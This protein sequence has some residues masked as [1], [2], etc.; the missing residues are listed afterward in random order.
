MELELTARQAPG[1][2][3]AQT[4]RAWLEIWGVFAG[5]RELSAKQQRDAAHNWVLPGIL[6]GWDPPN[7]VNLY[8]AKLTVG[9]AGPPPPVSKAA[10]PPNNSSGR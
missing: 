6:L 3:S 9:E 4:R 10:A 7:R 8:V 1:K 2:M 5:E